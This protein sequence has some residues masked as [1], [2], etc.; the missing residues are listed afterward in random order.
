MRDEGLPYARVG[1]AVLIPCAQLDTWLA[2]RV[3]H[4]Q[5]AE[6]LANEILDDLSKRD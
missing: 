4:E 2:A 3:A 5:R 6:S 1:G